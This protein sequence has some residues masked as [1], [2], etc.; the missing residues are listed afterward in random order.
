MSTLQLLAIH[1]PDIYW[2][3]TLSIPRLCQ[4]VTPQILYLNQPS[5]FSILWLHWPVILWI[6]RLYSRHH[7][8]LLFFFVNIFSINKLSFLLHHYKHHFPL[9]FKAFFWLLRAPILRF[10]LMLTVPLKNYLTTTIWIPALSQQISYKMYI[11]TTSTVLHNTFLYSSQ[12]FIQL[13]E[14][15]HHH[16]P[17]FTHVFKTMQHLLLSIN[18]PKI[19]FSI[20]Y[21][22]K[23]LTRVH[24]RP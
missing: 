3:L 2:H 23:L 18:E 17:L 6:L 20:H 16:S 15:L 24:T 4:P 14:M 9:S 8:N 7:I 13:K 22:W 12:T 5:T 10:F 11:I 19:I 21:F 1:I